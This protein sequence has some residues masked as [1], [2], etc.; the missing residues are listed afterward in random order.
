MEEADL[1]KIKNV[2]V[3]LD[4]LGECEGFEAKIKELNKLYEP[5]MA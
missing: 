1:A 5:V 3:N 4:K 2:I